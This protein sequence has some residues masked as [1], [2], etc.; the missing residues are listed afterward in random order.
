MLEETRLP[1]LPN[2][3]VLLHA[4]WRETKAD[5][6]NR[7][8]E[9]IQKA[10]HQSEQAQSTDNFTGIGPHDTILGAEPGDGH[11]QHNG[12]P[13]ITSGTWKDQQP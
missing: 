10:V 3:A 7:S 11:E 1:R 2:N 6:N 13:F 4:V 12:G 8:T 5:R 9:K